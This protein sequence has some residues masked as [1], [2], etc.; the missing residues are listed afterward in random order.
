MKDLFDRSLRST[1][2]WLMCVTSLV[3]GH[4]MISRVLL[5]YVVC[6]FVL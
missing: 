2:N 1:S 4:L 3:E 5:N 6:V